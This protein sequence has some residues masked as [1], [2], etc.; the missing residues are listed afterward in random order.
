MLIFF[1]AFLNVLRKRIRY[2]SSS[3]T[4]LAKNPTKNCQLKLQYLVIPNANGRIIGNE[5]DC[6]TWLV[7]TNKT[8][9]ANHKCVILVNRRQKINITN[10]I[11]RENSGWFRSWDCLFL[12][13]VV[14]W[15]WVFWLPALNSLNGKICRLIAGY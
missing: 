12:K 13:T 7:K 10:M 4:K 8:N 14:D 9:L 5:S 11:N 15:N 6:I 1:F 3:T 2:P